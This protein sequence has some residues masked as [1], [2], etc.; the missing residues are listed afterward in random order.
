[1]KQDNKKWVK[2]QS[3]KHNVSQSKIIDIC[4]D[5]YKMNRDVKFKDYEEDVSHLLLVLQ[6][7]GISIDYITADLVNECFKF[8]QSKGGGGNIED[9]GRLKAEHIKKWNDYFEKKSENEKVVE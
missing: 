2:E 4:I 5:S 8:I 7:Q 9:M 1:M 3:E 6:F